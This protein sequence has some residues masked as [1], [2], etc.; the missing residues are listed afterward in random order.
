VYP[1]TGMF[2]VRKL[3]L[4]ATPN[5]GQMGTEMPVGGNGPAMPY[6]LGPQTSAAPTDSIG[7]MQG[8]QDS[9]VVDIGYKPMAGRADRLSAN[10]V[11]GSGV[12]K[13]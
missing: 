3:K 11:G 7:G 13:F 8:P 5:F 9:A 2:E 12:G 4:G 10:I 6:G 1:R